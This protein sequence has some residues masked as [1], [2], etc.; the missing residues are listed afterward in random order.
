MDA[1]KLILDETKLDTALLNNADDVR[2]LFVF[3][4]TSSDPNVSLLNFTGA[5]SFDA[6]GY[7]LNVDFDDRYKSNKT[8]TNTVFTPSY[9]VTGVPASDGISQVAFGDEVISGEAFRY[10]YDTATEN[11]TI[12]NL[13]TGVSSTLTAQRFWPAPD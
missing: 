7:T 5:T 2:N 10:S 12:V 4:F 11:F 1:N 13:A 8:T 3:N 6:S 9:G